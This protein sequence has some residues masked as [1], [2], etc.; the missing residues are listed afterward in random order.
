MTAQL[1][2]VGIAPG[3]VDSKLSQ[4]AIKHAKTRGIGPATLGAL[5]VESSTVFF[6]RRL[7]RKSEAVFFPYRLDDEV[8]NWKATA[9][10]EKDFISK[11]G[12]RLCF[13][14]LGHVLSGSLDAVYITEGEW[15]A[16][17]LIEAGLP[18]N[19]VLSVPNGAREPKDDDGEAEDR[20]R[21]Y[22]YVEEAL[23][24]GLSRAKR[25]VWCG[26]SDSAGYALRADM[27]KILGAARFW[28]VEWPE[29]A[30]DANE[31]LCSDGPEVVRDLVTEGAR[32]W[33]VKGLYRLSE[34]PEPPPM[35]LW[36]PGFPEWEGKV[37]LSP[38]TL[39]VCTGHPGHG[40]TKLWSQIWF[41]VCRSYDVVACIA[42]FE[43]RPNPH[44]R[45]SLRT[46]HS[47]KLERDM[48]PDETKKADDWINA[49][50]LWLSHPEQRP[51][52][53]WLLDMAAT[54]VIR[55]GAKIVQID[56]WNRLESTK[57][58][59]ESETDY[60]GRCLSELYVFA[61]DF[62]CHVQV[63]AHP[64]KM[65]SARRNAPP[66]LED[67]AGSKNWDNRCDQ[68]FVIHRPKIFEGSE[69]KT[70]ATLYHRKARFEELG[71]P[72][73]LNLDFDLSRDRYVSADYKS[74][75]GMRA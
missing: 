45:R 33:P 57:P 39:S 46:L 66:Y 40:K 12:G 16:A 48:T 41:Q 21:G 18:I 36:Q 25:F 26:D 27:V 4:T 58:P 69:R 54:A 59:R 17:A 68:G 7:Q 19:S 63:L 72:C 37:W 29:G 9:F 32:P 1:G 6:P 51:T 73:K 5:G 43:T 10:P 28:F 49:H 56:P 42:S 74:S 35:T 24:M 55:Y 44:Q 47:G 3:P 13:Y 75:A 11:T 65:D 64:A 60:I 2:T 22:G 20:P 53:E 30:K 31:L 15:D 61:Q 38:G 70:E 14:N 67:I 23:D 50:Y 8:V 34:I 62:N 71:Y 52:L